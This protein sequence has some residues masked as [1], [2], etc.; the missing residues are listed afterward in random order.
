MNL[1]DSRSTDLPTRA[2]VTAERW[3]HLP[4]G[5]AVQLFTLRNAH[6]MR[7]AISDLGATLV[8][9][10][11]PDRAGR[12]ADVLLGHDTPAE[13]L[14]GRAYFGGTI[15]R[16]AN[17]IA[18]ARFTLDGVTYALDR[19]EG[20]N[21]LH[22]GAAGFHRALWSAREADGALVLTHESPEGDAGFPGALVATVR[23]ALDDDG[24]LT[25]GYEARADVPTPVS[26]TNH[27]YFNLSGDA[28]ADAP[29]IRGHVIAIEA[30]AYFE[31]DDALIPTARSDVAGNAFDFRAGAP[32]GARLDWPNAQLARAGGFDHCYVLRGNG[33]TVRTAAVLYDPGSG[34]E[35]TVA[36]DAHGMQ[37]YTG[38]FLDGI[39]GRKGRR[40]RKHAA[41]CLETGA[42]P[43]QVNMADAAGVVLRPG[44]CYRHTTSLRLTTR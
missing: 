24:T 31:V 23:Y 19:N 38:N 29:D 22:G 25:I 16:W 40:Y 13:Y 33:G 12:I 15:G 39:V 44:E 42:F 11:A 10:H 20:A 7:V 21:H 27:A 17:R 2:R 18:D 34:R 9:W 28:A 5:D 30:D 41:L 37:F 4:G 43:N 36:T 32:I 26:L 3:G 8:S 35:L 6:G 1:A 14:A